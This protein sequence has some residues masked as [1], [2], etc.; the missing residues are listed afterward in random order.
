[1]TQQPERKFLL[2]DHKIW[3]R[4]IEMFLK[5]LKGDYINK[6]KSKLYRPEKKARL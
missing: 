6:Q 5:L 1:M 3:R 4:I 2:L